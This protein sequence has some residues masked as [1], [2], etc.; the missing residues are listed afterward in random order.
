MS[1]TTRV[2]RTS[3]H[4][5][6]NDYDLSDQERE[7]LTAIEVRDPDDLL[8]PPRASALTLARGRQLV[9]EVVC[10]HGATVTLVGDACVAMRAPAAPSARPGCCAR[11][12]RRAMHLL[13]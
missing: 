4:S 9:A 6:H 12:A 10:G 13:V 8:A 2:Q 7:R 11:A 3:S 1:D 5:G